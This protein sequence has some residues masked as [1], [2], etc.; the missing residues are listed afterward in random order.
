MAEIHV[1]NLK[2]TTSAIASGGAA[3]ARVHERSKCACRRAQL[4]G[5]KG[6][7]QRKQHICTHASPAARRAKAL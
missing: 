1:A 7:G 3:K 5:L 2:N 4:R 6:K